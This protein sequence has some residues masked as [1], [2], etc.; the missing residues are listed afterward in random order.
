MM[1]KAA[2]PPTKDK[3]LLL[4]INLMMRK[5]PQVPMKDQCSYCC[6]SIIMS[7]ASHA[8]CKKADESADE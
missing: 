4:Q 3:K 5:V 6:R 2:K 8:L 7:T 1:R